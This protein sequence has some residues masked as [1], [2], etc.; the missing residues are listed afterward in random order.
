MTAAPDPTF[1][2]IICCKTP[3]WEIMSCVL[4]LSI[5]KYSRT[6]TGNFGWREGWRGQGRRRRNAGHINPGL[7]VTMAAIISLLLVITDISQPGLSTAIWARCPAAATGD[8]WRQMS[9][10]GCHRYHLRSLLGI[11]C[12]DVAATSST[13]SVFIFKLFHK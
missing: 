7:L 6:V 12:Q 4:T 9:D 8:D 1:D 2:P 11:Y 13:K 3:F 5:T 10:G